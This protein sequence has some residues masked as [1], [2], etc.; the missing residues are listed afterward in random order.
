[1]TTYSSEIPEGATFVVVVNE[2]TQA[3][4]TQPYTLTLSGLPCPPPPLNIETV[5]PNQTHLFWPTWAGGYALEA[6]SSLTNATWTGVTNEPI[7]N[8]SQF[9]V[10]NTM[11]P[12]N[13]F[14]RLYKP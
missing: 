11:N 5:K 8:A 3:S 4:G 7:V 9:N 1:M 6:V 12:T 10:T 14:Y 2:V 13:Q